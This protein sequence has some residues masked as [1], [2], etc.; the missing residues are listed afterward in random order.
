MTNRLDQSQPLRVDWID[1]ASTAP[2]RLGLTILPGRK[3]D[4]RDLVEDIAALKKDKVTH[5]V[6]LISLPEYG[7]YGVEG[8][9]TQFKKAGLTSISLPILDQRVC[10][11]KEMSALVKRL[12]EILGDGGSVVLHCVGGLGRSGTVAACLLKS[13]GMSAEAAMGEVR[14]ARSQRAIETSVQENFIRNFR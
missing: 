6:S 4:G 13:T 7:R 2:G 8:L 10:S 5:V 9:L 14:R 3:D 11:R 12:T 1:S